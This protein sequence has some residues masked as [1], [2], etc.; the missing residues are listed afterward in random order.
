MPA[1]ETSEEAGFVRLYGARQ[2][3]LKNVDVEFPR[4]ALTVVT[5]VS[6]SG[7]SSLAFDTIYAEG[8]RRYVECVSTYAKQFLERLPRPEYDRIDGL[9][10]AL[11]IRQG[12]ATQTGRSTVGT[13]T[14]VS[15]H[16]RLLLAR[17]GDTICGG[18][19]TRVPRHTVDS[20]LE[21]I[22]DRGADEIT[23]SFEMPV[24]PKEKAKDLWARALERGFVRARGPGE[25][26]W[27]RLDEP[28]PR[29]MKLPIRIYVHRIAPTSENRTRLR[30]SLEIAWREGHGRVF[31]ERGDEETLCYH[32]GRT[33]ERCGREFPEPLPQL[34][35]FN[36]PYGACPECRGF[37]NILTFTLRRVVRDPGK[38]LL[39][40]ALDPWANSWRAHFLP[41]VKALSEREG[42]PMDKP[43][44]SLSK[45]H[46]TLLLEGGKGF[47]G[48]F[49]FLERLREKS[50]KSSARFL[51][52]AYQEPMVCA[53]C[54]GNRLKPEALEVFVGGKNIADLSAM[55]V[56]AL[57]A[58]VAGLDLDPRRATIAATVLSELSGRLEYLGE[59][60]LDYL[61]LDRP[62]KTLS[63]G[64]AQR[65]ELANALGGSLSHALYVLDE[66]T[67]G[68]HPRDTERLIRVLRRLQ[69]RKN[70][71]LIVEHDPDVIQSADWILELGPGAGERGGRVLYQG[72]RE[73][74]PGR[75]LAQ[76]EWAEA[77]AESA[78]APYRVTRRTG[79]IEILGAR[80]H[81]LKGIDVRLP[82][83]SITG[84]CGV[85]GSGKSTLVEDILWRAAAR[86][87]G[88]EAPEP[89]LHRSIAGLESLDRVALVDQTPVMRSFRSN[90]VTYVKAFDRIRE[91]YARTPLARQRRYTPGTFS[92]NVKGGRCE[93]CEG[94]GVNKVEMYFL[95]DL[96]VPCESCGGRRYRPEVLEVTVHGLSLDRLLER[97]VE[98]ALAL[99]QGETDIQEPLW[100]LE[101]VGLGYLR[102]GQPLSTLSGGEVQRLKL[103]R[104]LSDR[105]EA[106]TLFI[107]DEPT[108]GLHRKDVLVLLRVLRELRRRGSTI[109]L[110]EHNLDLLSA[111][112]YLIELGP[113][114]GEAGGRLMAEGTPED[115]ARNEA[116]LTGRYLR[117]IAACA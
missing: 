105:T 97:T 7:K 34:F 45:E 109:V 33:C 93:V 18:C 60:G 19:G 77:V 44:R 9:A 70:T 61:T 65:I 88:E 107:L 108:V 25:R 69:A 64:E 106:A 113:E 55:T 10:P 96:W 101:R 22:L 80:E 24:H 67:V 41:K 71:L 114:G 83:G 26:A 99:F 115:L 59:T 23:I 1:P 63:G 57:R 72:P 31:V 87:F 66:P 89:G 17:V 92:F 51:V 2:N 11:A 30:E 102:L 90:P 53:R 13:V 36:S 39:E 84:V 73:G 76:A 52:K 62:S 6:G 116:S 56:G 37:G 12:A 100:V 5:G 117:R 28:M 21:A 27:A 4:A 98:E 8:Q 104:E 91:R 48:V 3:N 49:P 85:S 74:W 75:D 82:I 16:L 111:C 42:I 58:F 103:A 43:F 94:A 46:Q 110:V 78:T 50:Y 40:G 38:T 14:E 95:A 112:D 86:S 47:R 54:G 20:V 81:N 79:W 68:L 15:D 35:S 32:D 29:G